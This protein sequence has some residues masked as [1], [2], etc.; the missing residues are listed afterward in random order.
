[1]NPCPAY[2]PT[3]VTGYR[4]Q[5]APG[6]LPIFRSDGQLRLLGQLFLHPES[7]IGEPEVDEVYEA[8]RNAGVLLGQEVN[9]VILTPEEWRDRGSGFVREVASG[10]LVRVSDG[11]SAW[12]R[13]DQHP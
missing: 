9:A 2:R 6:L 8:T 10:P 13:E 11:E 1:M 12:D 5:A 4:T 7:V 3:T